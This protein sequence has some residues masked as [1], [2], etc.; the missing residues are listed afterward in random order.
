M[1][2]QFYDYLKTERDAGRLPYDD[3]M[4]FD[5]AESRGEFQAYGGPPAPNP[6]IAVAGP[7]GGGAPAPATPEPTPAQ[8]PG[9]ALEQPGPGQMIPT[10]Q[11]LYPPAQPHNFATDL[12]FVP[13]APG[14]HTPSETATR[15]LH[16]YDVPARGL[17]P[18]ARSAV[19]NTLRFPGA[20][21]SQFGDT[22]EAQDVLKYGGDAATTLAILGR[23]LA[24]TLASPIVRVLRHGR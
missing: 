1:D 23:A 17:G 14:E 20:F 5:A 21:G 3:A 13:L 9:T 12:G 11:N 16:T 24:S 6:N 19:M 8:L 2:K 15:F 22:P 18:V 4:A 7:I 10:Q